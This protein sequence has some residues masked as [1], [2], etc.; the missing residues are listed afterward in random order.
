MTSFVVHL[1]GPEHHRYALLATKHEER[2]TK[3]WNQSCKSIL[4]S[5][6]LR[7]AREY[8]KAALYWSYTG[9]FVQSLKLYTLE[10]DMYH[11]YQDSPR[12]SM[13]SKMIDTVLHS[14]RSAIVVAG[15]IDAR[16]AANQYLNLAEFIRRTCV[17]VWSHTG[18][19]ASIVAEAIASYRCAIDLFPNVTERCNTCA[20]ARICLV[21][22]LNQC[23]AREPYARSLVQIVFRQAEILMEHGRANEACFIS[24][25][26]YMKMYNVIDPALELKCHRAIAYRQYCLLQALPP[27]SRPLSTMMNA[28]SAAVA[29]ESTMD[30]S[31]D[32][33]YLYSHDLGALAHMALVL[34]SMLHTRNLTVEQLI[35][36]PLVSADLEKTDGYKVVSDIAAGIVEMAA[37]DPLRCMQKIHR[38]YTNDPHGRLY[39]LDICTIISTPPAEPDTP[40]SS[41]VSE[42]VGSWGK[43]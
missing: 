19:D 36:G 21:M 40:W 32:T 42:M 27:H 23:V 4:F 3:L 9:N 22:A 1:S 39:L 35:G 17:S 7:T 41:V 13:D 18:F 6:K 20:Q 43:W 33:A 15:R 5:R 38:Y 2:G 12:R 16:T 34:P 24:V 26:S 29:L 11:Q 28:Y 8:S 10:Q 30:F 25:L 31:R 14:Y 37:N